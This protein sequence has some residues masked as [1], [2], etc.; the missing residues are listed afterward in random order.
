MKSGEG[1]QLAIS[2]WPQSCEWPHSRR[3]CPSPLPCCCCCCCQ[4]LVLLGWLLSFPFP[5]SCRPRRLFRQPLAFACFGP[6]FLCPP[7]PPSAVGNIVGFLLSLPCFWMP[8]EKGTTPGKLGTLGQP[9]LLPFSAASRPLPRPP[10]FGL[11]PA[12]DAFCSIQLVP[13]QEREATV[14]GR[15]GHELRGVRQHAMQAIP[16]IHRAR[17]RL[18]LL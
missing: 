11:V 18:I 5:L 9:P 15:N 12:D 7:V 10:M 2:Q 17:M 8:A 14:H 3:C 4:P 1:V 6:S 16:G 13:F